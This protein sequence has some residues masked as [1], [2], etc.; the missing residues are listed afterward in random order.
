MVRRPTAQSL[1]LSQGRESMAP[2]LT[3]SMLTHHSPRDGHGRRA[4]A[5]WLHPLLAAVAMVVS[6]LTVLGNSVRLR[7]FPGERDRPV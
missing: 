1:M 4:A 2:A 7:R 6:G 5:G 3:V